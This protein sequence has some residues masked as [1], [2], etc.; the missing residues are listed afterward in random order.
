MAEKITTLLK[1]LKIML[2]EITGKTIK[3]EIKS[4]L[5]TSFQPQ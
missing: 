5:E 4:A 3:L 2:T 1:L